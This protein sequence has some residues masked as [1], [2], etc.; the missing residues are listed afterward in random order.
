[1]SMSW[2][3]KQKANFYL[4]RR[5]KRA[6]ARVEKDAVIRR[7]LCVGT[8][9]SRVVHVIEDRFPRARVTF[10]GAM[11]DRPHSYGVFDLVLTDTD[12]AA[13]LLAADLAPSGYLITITS[14]LLDELDTALNMYC[15]RAAMWED[16]TNIFGMYRPHGAGV[17]GDPLPDGYIPYRGCE[18][19]LKRECAPEEDRREYVASNGAHGFRWQH[20]PFWFEAYASDAEPVV[21]PSG[22]RRLVIWQ[23]LTRLD[24][25][26]GWRRSWGQMN[27]RRTGYAMITDPERYWEN[28]SDHA[29]RHR[30]QWLQ[31]PVY[32][33]EETGLEEF[34]EVYERVKRFFSL[35]MLFVDLVRQ[36]VEAHGDRVRFLIAR[37]PVSRRIIAGLAVLDIPEAKQSIHLISFLDPIG[38]KTSVG[39]AIIDYWFQTSLKKGLRFLDFDLFYDPGDPK[40]WKGFS[41]FKSQFGTR[42][43]R[44]PYPL[45]RWTG[46]K[47]RA[48]AEPMMDR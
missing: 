39:F 11:Y 41:A 24:K 47:K 1:M 32:S 27:A 20:G 4:T 42:F 8:Y 15:V 38:H 44:Y 9:S 30:K 25:P 18:A 14:R 45:I 46:G 19:Y 34:I 12:Q 40:S 16:G 35:R 33:M 7:V 6:M 3:D 5:W 36:K 23:P 22:P 37:D 10:I 13:V 21:D 29:K 31:K 17:V 48:L 43:V 2:F 28:W 26:K